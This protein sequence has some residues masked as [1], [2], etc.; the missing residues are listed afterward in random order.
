MLYY[1]QYSVSGHVPTFL[2][3]C[4]QFRGNWTFCCGLSLTT[5]MNVPLWITVNFGI[6]GNPGRATGRL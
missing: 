2:N 3:L 1:D 5:G 6:K 4:K